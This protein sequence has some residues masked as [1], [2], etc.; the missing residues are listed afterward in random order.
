M[1]PT[2]LGRDDSWAGVG[3]LV[4][5][6]N[7]DG[8]S[9]ADNLL[10]LGAEIAVLDPD[11]GTETAEFA[12]LLSVLGA[13]VQRGDAAQPTSEWLAGRTVDLIVDTG[14]LDNRALV[15]TVVSSCP[16][17]TVMSGLDLARQ[18]E[19]DQA[20]L[21]I[22]ASDT[23]DAHA[24]NIARGAAAMLRAGA[25][26]AVPAGGEERSPI[27]LVMEPER[28]EAML[29]LVTP[30]VLAVSGSLRPMAACVLRGID[31]LGAAFADTQRA[32]IYKPEDAATEAM[33][34]DADVVEGARAIGIT[35]G[36]PGLSM[37]GVVED[38]LCDRAFVENRQTS[39][40]EICN[41][42]DL[43]SADEGRIEEVLASVALA[44]AYG[45]A[46]AP[47]RLGIRET[48]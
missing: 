21:V 36:T 5:G 47:I 31:G 16:D 15:A 17:A 18:F 39:A 27:E 19:P 9:A 29:V 45:V 42:A 11:A 37:L 34:R 7:A 20:W 32:C 46:L 24:M 35:A 22:G 41:V 3:V 44:R 1:D 40:V 8:Q 4:I 33:V 23:E 13:E 43:S 38:V 30:D 25:V 26:A 6:F 2:T 48:F 10:H 14:E 28:Y 12:R